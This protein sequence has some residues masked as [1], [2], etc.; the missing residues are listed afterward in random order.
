MI[1]A[2][3]SKS[4]GSPRS[5]NA[6]RRS[7]NAN[8][9]RSRGAKS[10]VSKAAEK[11]KGPALAGGAA[12]A[13]LAGGVAL[14]RRS[15]GAKILGKRAGGAGKGLAEATRNAGRLSENLG[16]FAAEMRRTREAADEAPTHRSPIE[17]VLQALTA[18][19]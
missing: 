17:V 15:S 8:G 18:R 1:V 16:A 19:R 12:L 13:G 10:G 14:G 3:A 6:G 4:G 2:Q 11:A 5:R 9:S 7:R